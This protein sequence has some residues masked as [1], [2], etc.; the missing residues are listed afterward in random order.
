[1]HCTKHASARSLLVV[2][3]LDL[4]IQ[5]CLNVILGNQPS[6]LNARPGKT[7]K[8]VH[9]DVLRLTGVFILSVDKILHL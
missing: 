6:E 1:M 3:L 9:T 4:G 2:S 8:R 7:R 5:L